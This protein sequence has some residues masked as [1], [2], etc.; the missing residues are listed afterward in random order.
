M[1]RCFP[2]A[3]PRRTGKIARAAMP[4]ARF[5]HGN[6]GE[7]VTSSAAHGGAKKPLENAS[8]Y[9]GQF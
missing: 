2:A 9:K 3:I 8:G 7:R 1:A 4:G 5:D 6:R